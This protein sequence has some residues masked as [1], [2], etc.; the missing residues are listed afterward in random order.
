M[1][2]STTFDEI[3]GLEEQ[4]YEEGFRQGVEDGVK[5]GRIDGRTFGLE[6]GFEKYLESGRFYG[7]SLIWA[8]RLP[9]YTTKKHNNSDTE[10]EIILNLPP[11]PENHRL[12]KHLKVLHAVSESASLSTE[13]TEEAVSEFDDRLKRAQAKAKIVERMVGEAKGDVDVAE[14]EA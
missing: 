9:Q 4:F 13:N 5:A 11:L 2:Q 7:K 6:K 3:L 1:M 10:R 14:Q 8:N 12:A